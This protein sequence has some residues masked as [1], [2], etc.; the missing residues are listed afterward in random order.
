MLYKSIGT[1][2]YTLEMQNLALKRYIQFFYANILPKSVKGLVV[3]SKETYFL[4]WLIFFY[5]HILMIKII[6]V[7]K[8]C[9]DL[10]KQ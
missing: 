10:I 9:G 7:L 5:L 1:H 4:N 8:N 6:I 3:N 2:I